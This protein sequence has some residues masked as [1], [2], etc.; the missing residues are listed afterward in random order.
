MQIGEYYFYPAFFI[1]CFTIPA[2]IFFIVYLM[3]SLRENKKNYMLNG[4]DSKFIRITK[5]YIQNSVYYEELLYF[6][7]NN[8]EFAPEETLGYGPDFVSVVT[9]DL[10]NAFLH[11]YKD[12]IKDATDILILIDS[13]NIQR[14]LLKGKVIWIGDDV[15][16]EIHFMSMNEQEARLENIYINTIDNKIDLIEEGKMTIS[17]NVKIYP[18]L[19]EYTIHDMTRL[20][21][22]VVASKSMFNMNFEVYEFLADCLISDVLFFLSDFNSGLLN[23]IRVYKIRSLACAINNKPYDYLLL[24]DKTKHKTKK[25]TRKLRVVKKRK[26]KEE[27]IK[28]SEML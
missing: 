6:L 10:F 22:E 24:N 1:I 20:V 25:K 26:T 27:D 7:E 5:Q 15:E 17:A 16:R 9:K 13:L 21:N 23:S 12:N 19:R 18:K 4:I 3:F 2:F 8:K 11:T 28:N 14:E